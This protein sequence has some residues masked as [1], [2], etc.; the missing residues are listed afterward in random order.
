MIILSEITDRLQVV[1]AGSVTTNQLS[2]MASWRDVTTTT[3]TPGRSLVV[4]NNTTDVNIVSSPTTDTQ[5]IIDFLS[6][7]NA[8]TVNATVTIKLDVN[9]TDY[10]LWRGILGTGEM[11]QYND[12]S[13]FT[14]M[15]IAGAIKQSQMWGSNNPAINS[16]NVVVLAADVTNNNAT[17][18]T[19]ADVTGLS[20]AV[21]AGQTYWFE[22]VIPYTAA[23]T[24]TGSRWS[25]SGPGSPTMLNYRSEYTLTATTTTVNSATAY[26][27]PGAS[28]ASSLTTGDVATIWGII[29]P[30][31]DGVV[32]ARFA[33]EISASAI[34]AKAGATLRWMRI[35]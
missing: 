9:G 16:L 2:C 28:N 26:D 31:G 29:R 27:I 4:T 35:I 6:I 8:D 12:K 14:C 32:I 25:I 5:R 1:L 10:T 13:G 15:T 24:T 22:F 3:F 11:L 18:N 34:V 23:A 30:S 20:F 19:I 33:S 21:T 17:A 7:Y